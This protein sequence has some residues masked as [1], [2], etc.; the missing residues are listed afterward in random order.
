MSVVK[1]FGKLFGRQTE[2]QD[3]LADV[4]LGQDSLA[5]STL[6]GVALREAFHGDALNSVQGYP[7]EDGRA[8]PGWRWRR[9]YRTALIGQGGSGQPPAASAYFAD[10]WY[11]GGGVDCWLGA[12]AV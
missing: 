10:D 12:Q 8:P 6:D 1:Q 7:G 5:G 3:A 4:A 9:V 2:K 11:R